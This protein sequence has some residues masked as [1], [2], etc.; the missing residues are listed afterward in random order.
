MGARSKIFCI[1]RHHEAL[2]ILVIIKTSGNRHCSDVP[3]GQAEQVW[4]E[5]LERENRPAQALVS[6]LPP[7]VWPYWPALRWDLY[8]RD[9]ETEVLEDI[10]HQV[11][12]SNIIAP[13]NP[14]SPQVLD[15]YSQPTTEARLAPPSPPPHISH[16]PPSAPHTPTPPQVRQICRS[17][18]KLQL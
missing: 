8:V 11:L 1:I 9:L 10:C 6:W 14:Y 18:T 12:W 16:R 13:C 15:L 7:Q 3:C 4:S 2:L 5:G 17:C